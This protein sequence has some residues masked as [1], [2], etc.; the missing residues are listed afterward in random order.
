MPTYELAIEMALISLAANASE[1]MRSTWQLVIS[2]DDNAET[3]ARR[4]RFGIVTL[5]NEILK[6][7][8]KLK[9][10]FYF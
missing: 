2:M 10:Y 4:G 7:K 1:E 5:W 3:K 6:L 9:F 8:I